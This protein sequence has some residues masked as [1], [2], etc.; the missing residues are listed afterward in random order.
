MLQIAEQESAS[1]I[2]YYVHQLKLSYT[3]TVWLLVG[4]GVFYSLIFFTRIA[5]PLPDLLANSKTGKDTNSVRSNPGSTGSTTTS[6]GKKSHHHNHH[7]HNHSNASTS[8][9]RPSNVGWLSKL[10]TKFVELSDI[11]IHRKSTNKNTMPDVIFWIRRQYNAISSNRLHASI[12]VV[13]G[14][15]AENVIIVGVL[16]RTRFACRVMGHCSSG[17]SLSELSRVLFPGG[18]NTPKRIDGIDAIESIEHDLFSATWTVIAVVVTSS[19]LLLAQTIVLN[20]SYIS[21]RAYHS[22]EWEIV[23]KD[24]KKHQRQS[25]Y[26]DLPW[27][28]NSHHQS[29]PDVWDGRRKYLKGEEVYYPDWFGALYRARVNSPESHPKA[30]TLRYIDEQL[31]AELG[32]PATSQIIASLASIQFVL[33]VI[34]CFIWLISVV[35]GAQLYAYG[36]VWAI[37]SCLIAVHGVFTTTRRASY[38]TTSKSGDKRLSPAMKKLQKLHS[39]IVKHNC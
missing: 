1:M 13:L 10:Y 2:G 35:A 39:E 36:L 11:I 27:I 4:F 15:V 20:R 16:P 34:F 8:S 28:S 5:F 21:M 38:T 17:L 24:T 26:S 18:L 7:S 32:H 31:S 33:A 9:R 30:N 25:D 22:L 23:P 12:F 6:S 37:F 29:S 19:V 3:G 14:R